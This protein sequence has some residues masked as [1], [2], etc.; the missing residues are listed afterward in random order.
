MINIYTNN[1]AYTVC[2]YS[3][4]NMANKY[5]SMWFFTRNITNQLTGKSQQ[6]RSK[7][8]LWCS[9][10][11]SLRFE[12]KIK[13]VQGFYRATTHSR[14]HYRSLSH[15]TQSNNIF[16]FVYIYGSITFNHTHILHLRPWRL[17]FIRTTVVILCS[18]WNIFLPN[19]NTQSVILWFISSV[20]S[21]LWLSRDFNLL[22]IFPQELN[23]D[24]EWFI[25]ALLFF[26]GPKYLLC[27]IFVSL[28]IPSFDIL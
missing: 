3:T 2:T 19:L 10:K 4:Y 18:I 24:T 12:K 22:H 8:C 6:K 28:I 21:C 11:S 23:N 13:A 5:S 7:F 1:L 9:L 25:F 14:L 26:S 27:S 16:V 15:I 20:N 17:S